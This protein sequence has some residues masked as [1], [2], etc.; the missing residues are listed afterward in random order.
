M[1]ENYI[2]VCQGCNETTIERDD[3]YRLPNYA[4]WRLSRGYAYCPK[5]RNKGMGG[6]NAIKINGLWYT[7]RE[8]KKLLRKL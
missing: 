1:V 2:I 7:E 6:K 4:G 5:C 8:Y 3:L